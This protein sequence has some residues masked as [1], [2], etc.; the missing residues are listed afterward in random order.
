MELTFQ[1]IQC[2]LCDYYKEGVEFSEYPEY[3]DKPCPKCGASLLTQ[4]AYNK[5]LKQIALADGLTRWLNP[6]KWLNPFYY[7]RLIF[8]DNRIEGT[9]TFK[10]PKEK[11]DE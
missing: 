8:G 2:D 9:A 5:C 11:K 7:R 4:K 3:I 10:H 1:D 6:L